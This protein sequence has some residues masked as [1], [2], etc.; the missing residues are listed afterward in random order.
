[1]ENLPT[2]V[3]NLEDIAGDD[4]NQLIVSPVT[5]TKE[6]TYTTTF[7]DQQLIPTVQGT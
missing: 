5:C 4:I 6:Y 7:Q 3:V 2:I 1:M